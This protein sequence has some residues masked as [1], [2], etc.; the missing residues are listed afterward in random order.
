MHKERKKA[1]KAHKAQLLSHIAQHLSEWK[2]WRAQR[3]DKD[4]SQ[5]AQSTQDPD[6]AHTVLHMQHR[7]EQLATEVNQLKIAPARAASVHRNSPNQSS[8]DEGLQRSVSD[9]SK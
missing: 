1:D 3:G 4:G 8:T 6:I 5:E 2:E 7:L 9:M